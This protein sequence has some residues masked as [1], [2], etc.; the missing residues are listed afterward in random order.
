MELFDEHRDVALEIIEKPCS[1]LGN[2]G[3]EPKGPCALERGV[4]GSD[5]WWYA[6]AC[7]G[8][9]AMT[10]G[11]QAQNTAR[12]LV[13]TKGGIEFTPGDDV[14]PRALRRRRYDAFIAAVI[15]LVICGVSPVMT[16][17]DSRWT[18][19][20]AIS[21]E[22]HGDLNLDEYRPAIARVNGYGTQVVG[23]HIYDYF[24][25][26]TAVLVTPVVFVVDHLARL[27]GID[28]EHYAVV[29]RSTGREQQTLRLLEHAIA[30]LIG[31]ITAGLMFLLARERL[32]R[33]Q[34]FILTF[35]FVFA[36]SVWS[37]TTRALW[38][39]GPAIA[40]TTCALLIAV[41]ARRRPEL[42]RWL[43]V[44][45]AAAYVFRP[46][47]SVVVA[48]FTVYVAI[49]APRQ[50]VQYLAGGLAVAAVFV[51]VNITTYHTLL[52]AYFRSGR[53]GNGK[54]LEALLVPL[55]SPSR[56]LFVFSPVLL[57]AIIAFA[58][59]ARR[60][61]IDLL[62]LT[63][64]VS[65]AGVWVLLASFPDWTGGHTYGPRLMSDTLPL[66]FFLL[67]PFIAYAFPSG[68]SMRNHTLARN[69]FVVLVVT[70]VLIHARGAIDTRTLEWNV[71]PTD[72]DLNHSRVWDW[73]DPQ[74]LSGL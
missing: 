6:T 39:H 8:S 60:R 1:T 5:P 51:A 65:A 23:G 55:V 32:R 14:D 42:I 49:A 12:E 3:E 17:Y 2:E 40:A 25:W 28:L 20:A 31:A 62:D 16:S 30:S 61:E 54:F 43:G 7:V 71:K 11:A 68:A 73:R 57:I 33:K 63:A 26:G 29:Q 19:P 47:M 27:A 66:L 50:L 69:I 4:S 38:S 9:I 24:P 15:A 64:A 37:V 58:V 72:I 52:P 22:R 13:S 59:R 44:P 70:S 36:T 53:V 21:I 34:A 41:R 56:G 67:I 10:R 46:T 45:V 74:M 18:V 35:T 48:A